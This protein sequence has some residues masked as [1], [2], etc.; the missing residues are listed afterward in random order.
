MD[1]CTIVSSEKWAEELRVPKDHGYCARCRADLGASPQLQS[2]F[3][4]LPYPSVTCDKCG[5]VVAVA[6]WNMSMSL[7]GFEVVLC[8]ICR[9]DHEQRLLGVRV[10]GD[11]AKLLNFEECCFRRDAPDGVHP[12]SPEDL[13][14]ILALLNMARRE[15]LGFRSFVGDSHSRRLACW[16]SGE[17]V[18]YLAYTEHVPGEWG[19][20]SFWPDP[21]IHQIYVR[22]TF[23]GRGYGGHLVE[24]FLRRYP[25]GNISIETPIQHEAVYRI[26]QRLGLVTLDGEHAQSTGR[27]HFRSGGM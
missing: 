26:L 10:S 1:G 14:A 11:S 3:V 27:L 5:T 20:P 23:R 9:D 13:P 7:P 12:E 8:P 2:R 4:K 6:H 17:A 19:Q 21:T 24:E 22:S 18:G 16:A 15:D 25:T